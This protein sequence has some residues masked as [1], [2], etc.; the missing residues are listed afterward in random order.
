MSTP[1]FVD[2]ESSTQADGAQ[3]SRV[4]VPLPEDPYEAI[5]QAYLD[6]TDTES[7][8]FE[9]PI[10]TETPKLPLTIAPPTSLSE[11]T[12]PVLVPILC[13]TARMAVRVPPAMSSGLSSSMAEVAAMSESAFQRVWSSYEVSPSVSLPDLPSRKCYRGTSELVEDSMEDDGEEDEEIEESL[14]SDSVSEDTEDE[15]PTTKDEDSAAG[16]EGLAAGVEGPGMD[17]ESYGMDDESRGLDDEG[18]SIESDGLGLEEEEEA[19]P[20]GQQQAASVVGTAGSGSAPESER[21]ES[22]SVSRQPTLTTWTDSEDDMIYID[23]LAYPPPAPPVQ[24]PPLLEWMSGLLP[25]SLSPSVVPSPVSSPMIPL[26]VPSPVASPATAETEGFLTELGAQVDMQ[27]GLIRDH[28]IRLQKLSPALFERYNRDIGELFTR[29]RAVRDEIFS[30]RYRFRSLE[31]E[32]E[33]VAV[34]FGAI[35]RPVLALESWV[36]QTDAQR[37]ALWHAISDMQGV[38]QDLRLQLAEERRARLKLAKVVDSIRRCRA[39]RNA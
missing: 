36:G 5:R 3:S 22:V 2:P 31:Y 39:Q 29:S 35:W 32:Q 14:D 8:P 25:I 27:G 28:A 38:N 10:N 30:Q 12:P 1:V 19:V 18:H 37:A 34:T 20:G 6:G 16:D 26:T 9:D 24:T 23:V 4:P 13:K 7:E 21:P 11:S 17:E 15:G 33:R